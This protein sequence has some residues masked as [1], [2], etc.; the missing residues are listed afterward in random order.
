MTQPQAQPYPPDTAAVETAAVATALAA[1]ETV[2]AAFMLKAYTEFLAKATAAVLVGFLRFGVAPD[3][4]ALWSLVPWWNRRMDL[5]INELLSIARTGWIHAVR[6]LNLERDLPFDK[7]SPILQDQLNRTR[8]LMVRTPD[9]VYRQI[10]Q[11]L[12]RVHAAGGTLEAQVRGVRHV[13][14]VTG[15]ENWPS[16]AKTVAVTEVHR[17]WNMGALAA[18]LRAQELT[19]PLFKRWHA[20][21]DS[22]TRP[23]HKRADDQVVPVSQPFIVNMEA[24]MSPGDPAGSPSNVINC[25]CKPTFRRTR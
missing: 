13:L 2:I 12:D 15:T 10:L 6:E 18:A 5:L 23:G 1:L 9:E 16:R 19:G 20:K 3:P 11:V 22:A 14:D 25:R 24:L 21:D 8:N 17:A 4:N 7:D